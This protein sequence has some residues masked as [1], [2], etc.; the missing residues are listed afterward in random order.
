MLQ[1]QFLKRKHTWE[2]R[3][4]WYKAITAQSSKRTFKADCIIA[5]RTNWL[6]ALL[7]GSIGWRNEVLLP[8]NITDVP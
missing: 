6:G 4:E 7:T 3:F 5:K 1:Q 2:F 8:K